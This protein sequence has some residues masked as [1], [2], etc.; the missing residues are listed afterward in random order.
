MASAAAKRFKTLLDLR[1]RS[2]CGSGSGATSSL[3]VHALRM[4]RNVALV[5]LVQA[6][7]M[8][9]VAQA[10]TADG[11]AP[12]PGDTRPFRYYLDVALDPPNSRYSVHA[13]LDFE[14]LK[15]TRQVVVHAGGLKLGA[16]R[17]AS[18]E[19]AQIGYDAAR[20]QAIFRFVDTL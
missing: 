15:P 18:G 9:S 16:A 7:A 5:L 4:A 19:Q 17:L 1:N 14:V 8:F 20:Q 10:G 13:A 11:L 6:D 12:L 2:L 3:A